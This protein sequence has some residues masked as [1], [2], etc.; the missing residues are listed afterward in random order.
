MHGNDD[1]N[2]EFI[3][4]SCDLCNKMQMM[5]LCSPMRQKHG[6]P[7]RH[8]PFTNSDLIARYTHKFVIHYLRGKNFHQIWINK[9]KCRVLSP[10]LCSKI[11]IRSYT[12]F[13]IHPPKGQTNFIIRRLQMNQNWTDESKLDARKPFWQSEDQ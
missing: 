9:R 8:K 4:I 10:F 2:S 6:L 11:K 7:Q 3:K 5:A 12:L 1:I 13:K